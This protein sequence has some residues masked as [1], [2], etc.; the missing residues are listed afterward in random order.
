[1]I[2]ALIRERKNPPDNRVALTPVQC[3]ALKNRFPQIKLVV[4]KSNTRC[5]SDEAYEEVGIE[6]CTDVSFADIMIGIKEIPSQY[7]ISGKT[8]LFFSH[9]IK[10]QPY[11]QKMLQAIINQKIKLIDYEVLKW[12]TGQRVLGFGRFAGIVGAYNGLLTW[13]R[14]NDAFQL[15]PAWQSLDYAEI[16]SQAMSIKLPPLKIALTGGG[17]VAQ[18]ALD[19]LRS[20]RI[21]EVTPQ[22]YLHI[23]YNQ[24]VFVHL[25]SPDIYCHPE[26]TDWNTSYFYE[27]HQEYI[28][29]FEPYSKVTDILM[30]GIFWTS[31]LPPLFYRGD[32]AREDF[33][34]RV[35][36]DISCDVEGSV[37]ITYDATT[38][39]NP[40][41][42]WDTKRQEPC[43]PFTK[44]SIDIMAVGNLPNELP[45]DASE[46]FGEMMLQ[47]VL[48]A[49]ISGDSKL[50]ERATICENG[51]LTENFQYLNDY[52]AQL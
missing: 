46:E 28:S 43:A 47:H 14:R 13:G 24:P 38:I 23:D 39:Q 22:Q 41:I 7:L 27:H 21:K 49:V 12:E 11:N 17:R 19:F 40:F 15:P 37:P 16:L 30:N 6:T 34:I 33:K 36:A 52:I 18:G 44:D 31:D 25:N 10:K 35:I 29:T 20:L 1:M 51:K 45:K 2:L 50:I 5:F 3:V 48:P 9:T 26:K 32:T 42:G 8:Y 4:E